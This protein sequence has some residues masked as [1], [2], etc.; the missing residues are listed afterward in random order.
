MGFGDVVQLFPNGGGNPQAGPSRVGGAAQAGPTATAP[1][2]S[3]SRFAMP[4]IEDASAHGQGPGLRMGAPAGAAAGAGGDVGHGVVGASVGQA[5]VAPQAPVSAAGMVVHQQGVGV[6][7]RTK[8]AYR[9]VKS[10]PWWGW[11]LM[12][13]G[14]IW[15]GHRRRRNKPLIPAFLRPGSKTSGKKAVV[16][17]VEA[18]E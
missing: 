17:D 8:Q 5:D 6:W 1:D 16:I 14:S 9:L 4:S 2:A 15:Y 3:A 11:A 12:L 7:E 18:D 13:A 10:I